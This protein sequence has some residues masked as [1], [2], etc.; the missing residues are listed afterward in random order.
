MESE[1]YGADSEEYDIPPY[2]GANAGNQVAIGSE[3]IA[4]ERRF[5]ISTWVLVS[6]CIYAT[7]I[8]AM[9][10]ITMGY[11]IHISDVASEIKNE[12]LP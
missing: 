2:A 12:C 5:T 8:F 3:Q 9:L 1:R 6:I 4:L 10:G 7:G 11:A